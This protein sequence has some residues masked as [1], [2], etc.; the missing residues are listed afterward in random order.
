MAHGALTRM[1]TASRPFAREPVNVSSDCYV[2]KG[3]GRRQEPFIELGK[4]GR[5][6]GKKDHPAKEIA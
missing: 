2:I 3:E 1:L 5:A 6:G 4:V